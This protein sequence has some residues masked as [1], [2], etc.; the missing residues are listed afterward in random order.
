MF[1]CGR[2]LNPI[3]GGACEQRKDQRDEALE[4][5]RQ[6]QEVLK[7]RTAKVAELEAELQHE[8]DSVA[9]ALV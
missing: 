6:T 5:L 1:P 9:A 8:K 7:K 4:K 2:N 3:F